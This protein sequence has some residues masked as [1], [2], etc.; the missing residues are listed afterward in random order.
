M[1]SR[2][3]SNLPAIKLPIE[4]GIVYK[5]FYRSFKPKIGSKMIGDECFDGDNSYNCEDIETAEA[6]GLEGLKDFCAQRRKKFTVSVEGNIGCGKSTLLEYFKDCDTVE[7]IKE[8]VDKWTNLNGHNCLELLYQ[9]PA[10]WAFSFNQYAM[11]TRLDMHTH[12]PKVPVKMLERSL[13]STRY[14]FVENSKTAGMLTHL[15]FAVLSEWFDF[16]IATQ[17][18]DVDLFVYLRAPPEI[19]YQRIKKRNRKEERSG[20][21]F[22]F[23]KALH[24]LHEDWLMKNQQSNILP[25]P[26]LVL[27]ASKELPDMKK[28]YEK[29]S[30]EILCGCDTPVES[31]DSQTAALCLS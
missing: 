26:V 30:K 27:D 28:L 17:K 29:Y 5:K 8:P 18:I 19:C 25:A 31:L 23:I 10:R 24:D 22:E 13:Y 4:A 3:L 11:K 14:V 9:D 15:E 12:T 7:T 1:F 6:G 20:V 2:F 21:P 16:L